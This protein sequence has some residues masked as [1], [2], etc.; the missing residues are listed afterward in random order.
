M[1]IIINGINSE[2]CQSIIK[3]LLINN[4]VIG[5]YKSSYKGLKHKN[6]ILIKHKKINSLSD[7]FIKNQKIIFLNFA[8]R[9]ID[10]LLIKISNKKINESIHDN[11]ISPLYILKLI[12]PSMIKNNF[13]RIIFFSSSDAHN[14]IKGSSIYSLSKTSLIGLSNS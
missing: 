6:L 11:I 3:K 10:D 1:L 5:I 8:V 9:K 4:N 14:G 2:I 13:G 12:I 7:I